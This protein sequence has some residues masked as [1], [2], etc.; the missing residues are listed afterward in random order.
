MEKSSKRK[1]S[2]LKRVSAVDVPNYGSPTEHSPPYKVCQICR[3]IRVTYAPHMSSHTCHNTCH[4]RITY[5]SH[6]RHIR[7]TY[8][9][10][11]LHITYMYLI[12]ISYV[13]PQSHLWDCREKNVAYSLSTNI[14]ITLLWPHWP[15]SNSKAI[16]PKFS[17]EYSLLPHL[18]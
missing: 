13:C 14:V 10:H 5:A 12:H 18:V 2:H 3:H 17:K 11:T 8:L 16:D 6:T 7:V 1:I 4:I 9:S 15:L